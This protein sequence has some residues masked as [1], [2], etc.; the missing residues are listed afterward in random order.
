MQVAGRTKSGEMFVPAPELAIRHRTDYDTA[1]DEF[2]SPVLEHFNW[3]LDYFDSAA[4]GNQEP[5][6]HIIDGDGT[7][8]VRSFVEIRRVEL[9]ALEQQG[10]ASSERA[11][12]GFL[13]EDF[14]VA[15]T[16]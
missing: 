2:H 8:H 13:E 16:E 10:R 14:T 12:L 4:A 5:A 9:R 11:P 7:E 6:L 3:A 15:E 1:V